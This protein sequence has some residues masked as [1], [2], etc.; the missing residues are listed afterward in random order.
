MLLFIY[1]LKLIGHVVECCAC[2]GF[3]GADL[4]G[5]SSATC[6]SP[7]PGCGRRVLVWPVCCV[8]IGV[9][10][11]LAYLSVLVAVLGCSSSSSP[12][13]C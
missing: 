12:P 5:L 9:L 1:G 8:A 13:T 10:A 6:S 11:K 4:W 2:G 7:S 3:L